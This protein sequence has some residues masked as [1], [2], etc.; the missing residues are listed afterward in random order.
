MAALLYMKTRVKPLVAGPV[1]WQ[2]TLD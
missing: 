2:L 1:E